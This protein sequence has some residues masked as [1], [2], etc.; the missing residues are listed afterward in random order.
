MVGGKRGGRVGGRLAPSS[1]CSGVPDGPAHPTSLEALAGPGS[2]VDA[3]GSA[4]VI[5]SV[6]A[7]VVDGPLHCA[8]VG[9]LASLTAGAPL[10][11]SVRLAL[12][13]P[14]FWSGWPGLSGTSSTSILLGTSV[15]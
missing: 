8:S 13:F 7:G 2:A 14:S 5:P 1:V 3:F 11:P 15:P 4:V 6:G 12:A 10:V 9:A